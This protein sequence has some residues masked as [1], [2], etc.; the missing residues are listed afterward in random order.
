MA[1]GPW[2]LVPLYRDRMTPHDQHG[3]ARWWAVGSKHERHFLRD[4]MVLCSI[5][6]KISR[7]VVVALQTT[8][9]LPRYRSMANGKRQTANGR[10]QTRSLPKAVY[11]PC[12]EVASGGIKPLS[13]AAPSSLSVLESWKRF[14]KRDPLFARIWRSRCAGGGVTNGK[15]GQ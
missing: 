14:G 11:M 4:A 13:S 2:L 5:C 15:N 7:V 3:C 12:R 9:L 6:G 1:L 10:Q 8:C